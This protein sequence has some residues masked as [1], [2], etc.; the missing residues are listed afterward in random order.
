MDAP[1]ASR[2]AAE[3]PDIPRWVETRGMLLSG[4]ATITGGSS[5]ADGF[6]VRVLQG[7][8]SA[9]SVI[10]T[11]PSGA[12]LDAV[13]RTTEL[14]PVVCQTS[15]VEYV[16]AVLTDARATDKEWRA[17]TAI[18]HVL[19][20]APHR[21]AR[22][23]LHVSGGALVS[24]VRP[25]TPADVLDHLPPGLRYE[26]TNAQQFA[27]VAAVFVDGVPASFCY[28]VWQ[29]ETLWDVSIDTLD[30]YR[31]RGLGSVAVDF[32][33]EQM[34]RAGKQPVWGALA[35]NSSSLRL[36]RKLGFQPIDEISVVSRGPWAFLTAGYGS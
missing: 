13:A 31:G 9:M 32:M 7:A 6:V 33:M 26:M 22:P 27:P 11:P 36:A 25:L 18:V 5:M 12:I 15:N 1:L 19:D 30:E 24:T 17:E 29:T 10:G 28:A 14:T 34:S 20:A 21:R 8:M 16:L 3:L 2:L 35:S 4:H 23:A